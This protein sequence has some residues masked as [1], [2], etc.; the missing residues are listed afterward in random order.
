MINRDYRTDKRGRRADA[1]AHAVMQEIGGML[2][3]DMKRDAHR[4]IVDMLWR[5]GADVITDAERAE[6]GL[7]TRDNMGW[8]ARELAMWESHLLMKMCE[9][10]RPMVFKTTTLAPDPAPLG[11]AKT[12]PSA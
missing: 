12:P 4:A 8:T 5:I 10:P 6:I 9:P 3:S 1:L 7:E 2:Q 11:T